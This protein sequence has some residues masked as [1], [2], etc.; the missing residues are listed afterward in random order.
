MEY[1]SK[2]TGAEID[3]ILGKA[4]SQMP[5]VP[6]GAYNNETA[7]KRL[8]VVEYEGSSYLFL[9]DS[10]GIAPTGDGEVTV[11]LAKRGKDFAYD[12]FTP[13]QLEVLKGE[14]GDQGE[15]GKGFTILGYYDTLDLLKAAITAPTPGDTYGIGTAAPYDIYVFDGITND[16]VNNGM[17]SGD[18]EGGGD[19]IDIPEIFYAILFYEANETKPTEEEL[20]TVMGGDV[21]LAEIMDLIKN[22][23]GRIYTTSAN[24]EGVSMCVPIVVFYTAMPD[25]I[26][27]GAYINVQG[28]NGSITIGFIPESKNYML[29]VEMQENKDV[30]LRS[31][32][33]TERPSSYYNYS[34]IGVGYLQEELIFK[35]TNARLYRYRIDGFY[36]LTTNSDS[37]SIK[38]KLIKHDNILGGKITTTL[39]EWWVRDGCICFTG[40]RSYG[41]PDEN[42]MCTYSSFSRSGS[43]SIYKFLVAGYDIQTRLTI[44]WDSDTDT[45]SVTE[46]VEVPLT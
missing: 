14:K 33:L 8:D 15:P 11:L 25:G 22:N 31:D 21:R 13:D 12:D 19:I 20:I 18:G 7:Y 28:V 24:I 4:E 39:F 16:W 30:L 17:L 37:L 40:S 45:Y 27:A 43:I 32:T 1:N 35:F 44:K 41:D 6:R 38:N 46:R 34:P 42:F 29:D 5:F 36:E 23:T 26:I 9:K 2:Y 10:T 3:A